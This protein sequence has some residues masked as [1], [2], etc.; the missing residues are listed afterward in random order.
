MSRAYAIDCVIV[1]SERDRNNACVKVEDFHPPTVVAVAHSE[2]ILVKYS[3]GSTLW[4]VEF[5]VGYVVHYAEWL[6]VLRSAYSY[7]CPA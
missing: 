2:L 1:A 6:E 7:P 3:L 4:F 5:L